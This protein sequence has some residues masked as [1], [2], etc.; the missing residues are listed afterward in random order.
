MLSWTGVDD[1][2]AISGIS[3]KKLIACVAEIV[4]PHKASV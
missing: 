3:N 1:P 2:T 4:W